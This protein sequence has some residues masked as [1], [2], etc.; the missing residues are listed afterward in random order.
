MTALRN[1]TEQVSP[2]TQDYLKAIWQ[3]TEWGGHPATTSALAARFGTSQ[4][5]VSDVLSRLARAQLIVREPYRPC[6]LTPHGAALALSMVR[7]HRLIETHLVRSLGYACT[8]VHEDA[9]RLEHAA[10]D[11][12]IDRL[13]A[14]LGH[15]R[16]DP[17]GDPIPTADGQVSYPADARPATEVAP[18]RYQVVRISDADPAVLQALHDHGLHP[19]AGLRILDRPDGRFIEPIGRFGDCASGAGGALGVLA[20]GEAL[21][22]AD[23]QALSRWS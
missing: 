15:P 16:F 21:W 20:V 22:V 23:E 4:A 18:G 13:A 9:E 3:S 5:N 10:S 14:H 7:R 11:V 2:V 6:V 12:F 19:G 1:V 17:H 8:E